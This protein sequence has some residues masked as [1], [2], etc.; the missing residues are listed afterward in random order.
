MIA[1]SKNFNFNV[2]G[3]GDGSLQDRIRDL[4]TLVDQATLLGFV[5]WLSQRPGVVAAWYDHPKSRPVR[6]GHHF[7]VRCD[8]DQDLGLFQP[9]QHQLHC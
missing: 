1:T 8:P 2:V 7:M 6:S 5:F 4:A 9:K 3:E